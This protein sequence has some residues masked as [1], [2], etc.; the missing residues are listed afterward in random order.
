MPG[1]NLSRDEARER[2]E[3]LTVDG[4]DVELDVRSA[5]GGPGRD[6]EDGPL[7]FRS[8]TTIRFRAARGGGGAVRGPKPPPR[9]PGVL[10]ANPR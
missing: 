7:T 3:L 6:A 1:Q 2:A 9:E 4:Y 8:V 5:T 10:V